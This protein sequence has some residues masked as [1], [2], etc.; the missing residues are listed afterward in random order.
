MRK[1]QHES[2]QFKDG[3]RGYL[4]QGDHDAED[5]GGLSELAL[6][7]D[8]FLHRFAPFFV[9]Q[10]SC[11]FLQAL[12][13]AQ[14]LLVAA[15]RNIERIE[16]QV[17]GL[18]YHALHQ[19][20]SHSPWEDQPICDAIA[21]YADER[22]GGTPQSGLILDPTGFAKKGR[23]SVG[24]ARQ[25]LGRLGKVDNG[26]VGMVAALARGR[27]VCL[28]DK[29]LYLP[30]E[31]CED[32]ERCDRAKIPHDRRDY[33]STAQM[34][35]Q[36]IQRADANGVRYTWIGFDCEFG[37]AR[38][39]LEELD[40]AGKVYV[41]DVAKNTQVYLT[42]PQISF[43]RRKKSKATKTQRTSRLRR[44]PK[45]QRVDTIMAKTDSS[46]WQRM[47]IRTTTT[48]PLTVEILH[49]HVWVLDSKGRPRR[50]HLIIRRDQ[51]T[52][53]PR[54]KYSLSNASWAISTHELAY[55]QAQRF[56]VEHAIKEHKQELGLG[57]YQVR[58]WRAWHH[59]FT[60]VMLLGLFFLERRLHFQHDIPM[61]S[62]GD[63]RYLLSLL[64]RTLTFNEALAQ[65]Q[66]RHH[67]RAA[68]L[69]FSPRLE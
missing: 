18:D 42:H 61:L 30:R 55:R 7:L 19:F 4:P 62:A 50:R 67:Q 31:W 40:Q 22:L 29:E 44:K 28:I 24:V 39:L 9:T 8:R 25:W 41:A 11:V 34:A 57:E 51:Q 36:L 26:Q 33:R 66:Y 43:K 64:L 54:H 23:H 49:L 38:W 10:R 12:A 2:R 5:L 45:P 1:K 35:K 68:K 69:G 60:M 46:Q 59:H 21:S 14:G 52:H 15:K 58:L 13:F 27:D 37:K 65:I 3:I 16:E 47:V 6:H 56:W 53:K 32:S 17:Q 48:G 20:L 63:L